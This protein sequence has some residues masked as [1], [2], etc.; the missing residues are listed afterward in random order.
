MTNFKTWAE[1]REYCE[2]WGL[3]IKIQGGYVIDAFAIAEALLQAYQKG[4]K[5]QKEAP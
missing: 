2:I 3:K 5:D 4:K 1:A